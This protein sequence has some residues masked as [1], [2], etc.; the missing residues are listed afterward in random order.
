MWIESKLT[1]DSK[2]KHEKA[3]PIHRQNAATRTPGSFDMF[4]SD[5][6]L[7]NNTWIMNNKKD[8]DG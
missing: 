7:I 6:N 4:S 2:Q 8:I 1:E 5:G 3:S